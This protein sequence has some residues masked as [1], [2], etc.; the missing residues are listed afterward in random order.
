M[1]DEPGV[2]ELRP[3][4]AQYGRWF[5]RGDPVL[6]A[7]LGV[8]VAGSVVSISTGAR[9]AVLAG[10]VVGAAALGLLG[11]TLSMRTSSVRLGAGR[12]EHRSWWVHHTVLDTGSELVGVLAPY[13]AP[14]VS[15]QSDLLVVRAAG[16]GPRVRLN[17][18][19]WRREDLERIASVAGISPTREPLDLK[20]FE[21]RVPGLMYVWERHWLMAVLVGGVAVAAGAVGLAV[22]LS[23]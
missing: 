17:G 11:V 8:L 21:R 16:G 6:I 20:G 9:F 19:F 4:A 10:V 2:V 7:F 3:D 13:T 22:L 14:I 12:I 23:A 15:R 1:T 18:A 5:R